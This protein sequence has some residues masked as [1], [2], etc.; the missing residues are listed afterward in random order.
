MLVHWKTNRAA[1]NWTNLAATHNVNKMYNERTKIHD[2][3]VE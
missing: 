2:N 1:K 3:S